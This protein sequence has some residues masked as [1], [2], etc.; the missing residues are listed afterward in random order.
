MV[1]RMATA[2]KDLCGGALALRVLPA[3][4]RP[5]VLAAV[6]IA[7]VVTPAMGQDTVGAGPITLACGGIGQD[8]SSQMRALEKAHSLMIL[9]A[10]REGAY[11]TDV[12]T[13]IDDPLADRAIERACGPIGLADVPVAGRYRITATFEGRTQEHWLALAP[14]SGKRL[15]LSW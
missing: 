14:M 15:V 4:A 8:E 10:T 11:L 3:V 9:F 7:G 1:Q 12:V 2:V 6:V 5:F 13:R